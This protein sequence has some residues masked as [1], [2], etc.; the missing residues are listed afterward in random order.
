MTEFVPETP[1]GTVEV[2]FL[3]DTFMVEGEDL[4]VFEDLFAGSVTDDDLEFEVPTA[5]HA[6]L[7][8]KDQTISVPRSPNPL[9]NT[10]VN[11][12]MDLYIAGM[13]VSGAGLVWLMKKRE[14]K[15]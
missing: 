5:S 8:D 9:V 10:G 1:A 13:L 12:H 6:D 15:K 2:I 3:L 7:E 4:V 11:M 14:R